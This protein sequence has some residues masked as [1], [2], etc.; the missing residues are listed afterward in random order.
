MSDKLN[1]TQHN[2]H[3]RKELT[4]EEILA[5]IPRQLSDNPANATPVKT[6]IKEQYDSIS[7]NSSQG[8]Y[9]PHFCELYR[10]HS[11]DIETNCVETTFKNKTVISPNKAKSNDK[12]ATTT[13]VSRLKPFQK[14]KLFLS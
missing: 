10:K 6:C 7:S 12:R 5:L 4:D 11:I 3:C 2:T 13:M 14:Q 8:Y 1:S 9:A